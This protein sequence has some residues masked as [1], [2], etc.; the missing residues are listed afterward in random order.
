M[1]YLRLLEISAP[2]IFSYFMYSK[3][4]KNDVKKKQLEYNIQLMNEKLDNLYI[5]IYI[6]HTTNIL[7]REKFIVLK[8]DCGDISYYFETFYNMDK[9]LAKNIKYISKEIK[10]M[11]I[12]FHAYIINRITLEISENPNAGFI[13]S[14]E[15]YETHFDLLNRTYFKIYQLLMA[16]Y[17]DI[18][19][20][21]GLPEPVEKFD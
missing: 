7:T 5:P 8:V 14:D 3:T 9:I 12:E 13:T 1:D 15:I 21:L 4:L 20:K 6:S 18:C 10:I 17:R 16:E 2:L 19:H 11:F